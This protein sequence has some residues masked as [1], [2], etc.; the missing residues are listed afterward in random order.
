MPDFPAN[1]KNLHAKLK[2]ISK[3]SKKSRK[4]G[5]TK[6]GGVGSMKC[7]MPSLNNTNKKPVDKV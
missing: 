6:H 4:N 7:Q 3:L 1:T 2:A 5:S